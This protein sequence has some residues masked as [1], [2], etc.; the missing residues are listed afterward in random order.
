MSI[1]GRESHT[2]LYEETNFAARAETL[3]FLGS[4][5]LARIEG[6]LLRDGKSGDLTSL[7]QY[8]ETVRTRLEAVDEGLFRRL[9]Q[10]I[11]S[12]SCTRPGL[13]RRV[14]AY[15]GAGSGGGSQVGEG[16]DSLDVLVNG[17]LR[18]G[19]GP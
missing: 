12:G 8:A 10:N 4:E 6:L 18:G 7:K 19:G 11:A 13:R 16:Y 9:R 5:V 2:A 14:E 17:L 15:A 1:E 3:D